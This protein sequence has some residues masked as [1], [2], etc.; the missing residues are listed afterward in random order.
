M[1]IGAAN[2]HGVCATPDNETVR[3]EPVEGLPFDRLRA[4]GGVSR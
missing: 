3:P 2:G 4:N 1:N